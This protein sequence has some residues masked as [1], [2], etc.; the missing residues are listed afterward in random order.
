MLI[1]VGVVFSF[2][3]GEFLAA[4]GAILTMGAVGLLGRKR[5]LLREAGGSPPTGA[6][7][8]SARSLAR[9]PTKPCLRSR[10]IWSTARGRK[11]HEARHHQRRHSADRHPVGPTSRPPVCREGWPDWWA[12]TR[13]F[14]LQ[15]PVVGCGLGGFGRVFVSADVSH[16]VATEDYAHD[17]HSI[18]RLS[19]YPYR[20]RRDL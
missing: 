20:T 8:Q 5:A 4:L 1:L 13:G 3:R 16:P 19:A 18:V 10:G 7:W 12:A 9:C 17:A 11:E 14:L 6:D 2:S 15:Y